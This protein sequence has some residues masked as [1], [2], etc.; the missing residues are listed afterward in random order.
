MLTDHL[1]SLHAHRSPYSTPHSERWPFPEAFSFGCSPSIRW[2]RGPLFRDIYRTREKEVRVGSVHF[3]NIPRQ[4]HGDAALGCRMGNVKAFCGRF[5]IFT[6]RVLKYDSISTQYEG[7]LGIL[8]LEYSRT[9][10][11]L[12][13]LTNGRLYTWLGYVDMYC[14]VLHCT[15]REEISILSCRRPPLHRNVCA[16]L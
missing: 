16:A 14:T 6:Y 9:S 11:S 12:C 3:L 5:V 13:W 15:G 1:F 2:S 8:V 7:V 10:S 4:P